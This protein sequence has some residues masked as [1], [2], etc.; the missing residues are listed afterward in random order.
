MDI[1]IVNIL[2]KYGCAFMETE[3]KEMLEEIETLIKNKYT[4]CSTK[5]LCVSDDFN[6]ITKGK[7]YKMEDE[8]DGHYV[9][10][11]NLGERRILWKHFFEIVK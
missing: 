1:K 3:N 9:I 10:I 11:D 5:L 2:K 7:T 6:F 4:G 8:P